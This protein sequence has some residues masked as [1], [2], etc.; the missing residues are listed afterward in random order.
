MWIDYFK[1]T[2]EKEAKLQRELDGFNRLVKA[3]VNGTSENA[4]PALAVIAKNITE[5]VWSLWSIRGTLYEAIAKQRGEMTEQLES[6]RSARRVA[7]S[8]SAELRAQVSALKGKRRN[9]KAQRNDLRTENDEL[10]ARVSALKSEKRGLKVER[11]NLRE[12]LEQAEAGLA[13]AQSL[14][15]TEER[16]EQLEFPLVEEP[17]DSDDDVHE[18]ETNPDVSGSDLSKADHSAD[19]EASPKESSPSAG[20]DWRLDNDLFVGERIG[21]LERKLED[22][23][24]QLSEARAAN[25]RLKAENQDLWDAHLPVHGNYRGIPRVL[26]PGRKGRPYRPDLTVRELM[27]YVEKC[28]PFQRRRVKRRSSINPLHR[29]TEKILAA[30]H[31]ELKDALHDPEWV[32]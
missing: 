32:P 17:E 19:R 9:L 1:I 27:A 7:E 4:R 21:V 11:N 15:P 30:R 20:G 3:V 26:S 16:A 18:G 14:S 8:D 28:R 6:E 25:Q 31:E 12:R 29:E 10:R 23:E 5:T 24:K 2:P 13:K 22:L